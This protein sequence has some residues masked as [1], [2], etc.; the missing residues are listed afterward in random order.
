MSDPQKNPALPSY[1]RPEV[2]EAQPLQNLIAD[3]LDGTPAF[4]APDKAVQYLHKW[5][6]EQPDVFKL[7][8]QLAQVYE[9][10]GRIVTAS[11][12]ML[13]AR[14]PQI[15]YT[16]AEADF[17]ADFD[18]IDGEGNA[19]DVFA[20]RFAESAIAYGHAVILVDHPTPPEGVTVTPQNERELGLR[21]R[22]RR[23][24]RR[25]VLSWRMTTVNNHAVP[26]QV[27][28]FE[29]TTLTDGAFG[30]TTVHRY[31]ILA[32]VLTPDGYQATWRVEEIS[33][34]GERSEVG[35]GVYVD[36]NGDIFDRLPLAVAYA[37]RTDAPFTSK[38][39][40]AGVAWANLGHYQQS[41]NLRFY[42]EVA[43]FPQP[44]VTGELVG[45]DGQ[46]THVLPLG[47]LAG[48]QLRQPEAKYGWTELQGTSLDQVEKGI[49]DCEQQMGALGMA[50]LVRETRSAETA[51]AK[52]L[53]KTA[54]NATLATAAQGLDDAFNVAAEFH[55]RYIG[56]DPAD[57]PT[58]TLNREFDALTLT[59]Q[60]LQAL[61]AIVGA[62]LPPRQALEILQ[63]GGLIAA[64]ADL[65]RLADDWMA[66]QTAADDA[67]AVARES[68]G[69][70]A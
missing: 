46:P 65:D 2:V 33:D 37:G 15:E 39:P 62:G 70:A 57:A 36:A 52:R 24:D 17:T 16:T 42:R 68:M 34:K 64:D 61:A 60:M 18:N 25:S 26:Q 67:A 43:A 12:G 11:T 8:S 19:L 53:D 40:L 28:F 48:V 1:T 58:I 20:K 69:A 41:A 47:P 45:A 30:V 54:E 56:V 32:L 6:D 35:R 5:P 49:K 7:R 31:R 21:P 27:V 59:P 55:A 4:H 22:W 66:G 51:E 13:F 44:T 10:F 9:G 50:F 3:L 29:P 23:Y 63:R 38:P 14:P